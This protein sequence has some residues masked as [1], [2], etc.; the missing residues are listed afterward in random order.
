MRKIELKATQWRGSEKP[1]ETRLIQIQRGEWQGEPKQTGLKTAGPVKMEQTQW[2]ELSGIQEPNVLRQFDG[3]NLMDPFAIKDNFA[4][5]VKNFSTKSYPALKV[6]GGSTFVNSFTDQT[7]GIVE[8]NGNLVVATQNNLWVDSGGFTAKNPGWTANDMSFA[9]FKGSFSQAMLLMTDGA[10]NPKKFDGTTISDLA[11]AQAGGNYVCVH[12]N[13][14]YIAKNDMLYFSALRKAEDWT[15]V[16]D[17]GSI[18]VESVEGGNITGMVPNNQRLTIFKH[19]SVHELYGTNPSNFTL[20]SVT[21]TIGC[22]NAK[23][24]QVIDGY[25]YFLSPDGLFRYA[26]GTLP[27]SEFSLQVRP[28]LDALSFT[29]A[30]MAT[31]W[32]DGKRYYISFPYQ[33]TNKILEYDTELNTWNAWDMSYNIMT[34]GSKQDDFVKKKVYVSAF[35]SVT[36]KYDLTLLDETG[37]DYTG[38][39]TKTIAYEWV[40]KPFTFASMAAKNR[41]LTVW[42]TASVPSGS[43]LRVHV[44]GDETGET[45]TQVGSFTSSSSLQSLKFPIPNDVIANRNWVRVRVEGTGPVTI[46]EITRQERTLNM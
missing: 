43:A 20:K 17:S 15:T 44:S 45:W 29:S 32:T 7:R 30:Q 38:G 13:R 23:T 18:T 46:H 4:T 3:M 1:K 27:E 41:W 35:N 19:N 25:V 24:I 2:T 36:A 37:Q 12:A 34:A 14:V 39:T 6:R 8:Y 31:S 16:N 10:M 26:G 28:F 11:G 42:L 5:R 9:V 40:S 22:P 33:T 21:E